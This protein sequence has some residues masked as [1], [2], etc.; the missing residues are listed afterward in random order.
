MACAD[1]FDWMQWAQM[2]GI[3]NI[4]TV[5]I[6]LGSAILGFKIALGARRRVPNLNF[7]CKRNRNDSAFPL[8]IDIEIRNFTGRTVVIANPFFRFNK[9]ARPAPN[10]KGDS[11]SGEYEIKFP[12][13]PGAQ[14]LNQVEYMLR[15]GERVRTWIPIDPAHTDD[16][17]DKALAQHRIGTIT[18]VCAWLQD[19]P[20]V[21]KL[22]RKI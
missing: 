10:A 6:G 5:V 11:P 21:H 18:C 13:N 9:V 22:I 17:V 19:R 20:K 1:I 7:F 15:H 8:V 4:I 12:A 3:W 2:H 14:E 16:E